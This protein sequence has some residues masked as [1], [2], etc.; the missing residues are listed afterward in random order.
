MGRAA[1]TSLSIEEIPKKRMQCDV[2]EI[3]ANDPLCK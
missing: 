1:V 2:G 3:C